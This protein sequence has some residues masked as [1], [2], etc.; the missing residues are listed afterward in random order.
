MY[1]RIVC[2]VF[3]GAVVLVATAAAVWLAIAGHTLQIGGLLIGMW[4]ILGA[5]MF[6]FRLAEGFGPDRL[7]IWAGPIW[8]MRPAAPAYRENVDALRKAA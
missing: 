8:S 5:V 3:H 7:S 1:R 4:A 2:T 6:G